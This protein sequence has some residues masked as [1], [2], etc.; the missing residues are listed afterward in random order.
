MQT[1]FNQV[2]IEAHKIPAE[3]QE[4]FEPALC[5][6]CFVCG[7][8]AV[9]REVWRVLN[10][11]GCAFVNLGDSYAA[12]GRG[13]S[14][15]N[16]NFLGRGTGISQELGA[17]SAPDGLKP[18][19][20]VGIP[21]RTAFALQADGWWLRDAIIWAKA[22]VDEGYNLEGS[23]MPGSQ[24]DRFTSAYEFVFHLTKSKRYYF[25]P[26]AIKTKSGAMMRNVWRINP[27]PYSGVDAYGMYRIASPSCPVHDYQHGLII[28]H[29]YG[30]QLIASG[31]DRNPGRHDHLSQLREGDL[32]SIP[33]NRHAFPF[34]ETS[35]IL[36][37]KQMSKK[38]SR[39]IQSMIFYG[40]LGV[41]TEYMQPLARYVSKFFHKNGSNTSESDVLDEMAIDPS[42]QKVYHIL[43]NVTFERP[44]EKCNCYYMGRLKVRQDH[45]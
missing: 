24:Q 20:L 40:T 41:H 29:E 38:D 7:L 18:K 32:L 23:T 1:I 19:D 11:T 5:D 15:H 44:P 35:A 21:W 42:D 33:L 45:Y 10:P 3:L 16:I 26:E 36:H 37:N 28:A 30:E 31:F 43:G 34:Y 14:E 2:M 17:R 4:Y 22:E 12:G 6:K 8:V 13:M 27:Q 39:S 25:D 9:F